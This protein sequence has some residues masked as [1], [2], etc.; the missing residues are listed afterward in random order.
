[1]ILSRS[2]SR[3]VNR[4]LNPFGIL[5]SKPEVIHG[6]PAFSGST[7]WARRLNETK[8][9]YDLVKDVDGVVIESGVHWGYGI[10]IHLTLSDSRTLYGFDSFSGHS[11]PTEKDK[12]GGSYQA[13][14]SSFSVTEEDV[15]KT[16]LLGL[17]KNKEEIEPKVK[18]INGW[19]KDTM[20]KWSKLSSDEGRKIAL[21]HNDV[22]IY[23][24]FKQTLESCWPLVSPGG[25]VIL[26]QLNDPQLM[27]KT[28]AVE[29]F[30]SDLPSDSYELKERMIYDNGFI[31]KASHYLMKCN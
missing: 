16:L 22:D 8:F 15:W 5:V 10:L 20:P 26:G 18:L 7:L 30:L 23:E 28:K 21:V 4:L 24:P 9:F 12:L 14:D 27:G 2:L 6:S 1:M 11:K 25:C 29:E 3:L 31:H 17:G 19:I 13:L